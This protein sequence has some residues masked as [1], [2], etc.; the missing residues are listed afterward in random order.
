MN[1]K[2][3]HHIWMY[4]LHLNHHLHC[5]NLLPIDII[6]KGQYLQNAGPDFQFCKIRYQNIIHAGHIELHLKSSDW[7][8]HR[9]SSDIN[10]KNVVLHVVY[11][12]DKEIDFLI[13]NDIPTLELKTFISKETLHVLQ[14]FQEHFKFIPC[15]NIFDIKFID[16]TFLETLLIKK[17]DEKSEEFSLKLKQLSNHDEA[18]LFQKLAY[19]FGLKINAE[20]FEQIAESIDFS[21]IRKIQHDLN[22]LEAL[23]YGLSGWL[24]E[25]T[26][27]TSKLWKTEFDYLKIK[28]KIPNFTI[29]PKFLRLRPSNFPTIRLSQFANFY[30]QQ[31]H[32]IS[33]IRNAKSLKELQQLFSN[34]TANPYWNNHFQMGKETQKFTTKKLSKDFINLIII[35]IVLPIIYFY[36]KDN[37][38]EILDRIFTLY[39]QLPPDQNHIIDRWNDLGIKVN[40][41]LESQALLYLYKRF[42]TEKK[43]LNCSIGYQLL[44]SK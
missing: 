20:I 24:E 31:T 27:E 14:T 3:L 13:Q 2:W 10:Y 37:D 15:E 19:G 11:E 36:N 35:N 29:A 23:F 21:T 42:C 17:L 6:D 40:N 12:H 8:K 1:E 5:T 9:H 44:K 30:H 41:A 18:L 33:K 32:L 22:Q 7:E 25:A 26:D 34:T 4:K 16:R 43:C 39:E 28:F 38:D